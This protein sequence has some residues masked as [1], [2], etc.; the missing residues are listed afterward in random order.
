MTPRGT[1]L[2]PQPQRPKLSFRTRELLSLLRAAGREWTV[3]TKCARITLRFEQGFEQI[4]AAGIPVQRLTQVN[5]AR[6]YR[7]G[8]K[9]WLPSPP[10]ATNPA[11]ASFV[12]GG[13]RPRG[14][15]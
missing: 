6:L 11:R 13:W 9:P 4:R 7:L 10:P 14:T 15:A 5:G 12:L 1:V 2:P 8:P 3:E